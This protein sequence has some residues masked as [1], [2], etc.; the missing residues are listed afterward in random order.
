[1]RRERQFLIDHGDAAPA[2]LAWA[3][4]LVRLPVE[5][6]P[7]GVRRDGA[8]EYLH[9]CRLAGT[10]FADE[11]V[12]FAGAQFQVDTAQGLRRAEVLGNAGHRQT[13]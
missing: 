12:D 9:E 2:R 5:D 3:R 8:A 13:G 6:H 7:A 4:R 10:V 1:V 11:R